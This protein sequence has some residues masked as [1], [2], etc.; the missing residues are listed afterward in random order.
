MAC[1]NESGTSKIEVAFREIELSN[2]YC[3]Q[4][5]MSGETRMFDL[6]TKDQESS[7]LP[8]TLPEPVKGVSLIPPRRCSVLQFWCD[9]SIC[10]TDIYKGTMN[11]YG[12]HCL[13]FPYYHVSIV[14]E[15]VH[16]TC[17]IDENEVRASVEEWLHKQPKI[18]QNR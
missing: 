1:S 12:P 16:R 17:E 5:Y 18:L 4:L 2:I 8:E 11:L 7:L 10:G 3:Q 13:S 6:A 14:Q 9:V 15:F